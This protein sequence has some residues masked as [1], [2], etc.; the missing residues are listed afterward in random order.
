[1]LTELKHVLKALRR[2]LLEVPGSQFLDQSHDGSTWGWVKTYEITIFW[3][4]TI[5]KN[6]L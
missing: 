2:L 1:M 5:Q 3:G 4:M 6:Q